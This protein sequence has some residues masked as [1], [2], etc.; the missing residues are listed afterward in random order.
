M[1]A[2]I[3][4]QKCSN[5]LTKNGNTDRKQFLVLNNFLNKFT[6]I[7]KFLNC[8]PNVFPYLKHSFLRISRN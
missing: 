4:Q 6:N 5:K 7:T 3:L 2:E 1:V 8:A